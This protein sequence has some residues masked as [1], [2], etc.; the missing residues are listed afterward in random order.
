MHKNFY[1]RDLRIYIQLLDKGEK[2]IPC[3]YLDKREREKALTTNLWL[4]VRKKGCEAIIPHANGHTR[5]ALSP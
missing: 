3:P 5:R 2:K 1:A 4:F